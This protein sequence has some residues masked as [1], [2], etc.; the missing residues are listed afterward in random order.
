MSKFNGINPDDQWFALL[1]W[2]IV[3]LTITIRSEA[4]SFKPTIAQIILRPSCSILSWRRN[5]NLAWNF[6]STKYLLRGMLYT[7]W[8]VI[9]VRQSIDHELLYQF[10]KSFFK[11]EYYAI[12]PLEGNAKKC[13]ILPCVALWH[14]LAAF[15][16]F[17][18]LW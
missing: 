17:L 10:C 16:L 12:K 5:F 6:N 18:F 1:V 2:P 13:F 14:Q 8:Y 7:T 3:L 4:V 11:K 15:D 9:I